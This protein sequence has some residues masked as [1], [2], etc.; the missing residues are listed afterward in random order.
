MPRKLTDEFGDKVNPLKG[1]IYPRPGDRIVAVSDYKTAAHK[2]ESV[3]KAGDVGIVTEIRKPGS[4]R[5]NPGYIGLCVH[6]ERVSKSYPAGFVIRWDT[7]SDPERFS[8]RPPN[9]AE[10]A[11]E[12][13]A[14]EKAKQVVPPR[15]EFGDKVQP[16]Q[17]FVLPEPGDEI[18]AVSDYKTSAHKGETVVRQGDVGVVTGIRKPGSFA[19][20]SG[21]IGLCVHFKR[22]SE[23]YPAGFVV[24]WDTASDP[25]RFSIPNATAKEIAATAESGV[26]Q[27][28]AIFSR[29]LSF[30]KQG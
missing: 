26:P 11:A 29:P 12:Q 6:F 16:R 19:E 22:V 13:A 4:F 23:A 30:R 14:A 3:V 8:L 15:D 24:R 25:S 17:G 5:K 20:S 2:G 27:S 9:A 18:I 28:T 10:I 7:A 21:Y 1:F